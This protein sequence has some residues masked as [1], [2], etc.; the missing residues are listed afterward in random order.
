MSDAALGWTLFG[1]VFGGAAL[2]VVLTFAAVAYLDWS[3]TD[4]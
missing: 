1:I 2:M 4:A 3:D